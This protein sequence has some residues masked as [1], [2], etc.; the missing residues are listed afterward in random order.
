[1]EARLSGTHMGKVS[2]NLGE[3]NSYPEGSSDCQAALIGAAS[4]SL[5][6]PGGRAVWQSL[7]S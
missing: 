3:G 5:Q 1:M 4:A 2:W 6:C 7:C